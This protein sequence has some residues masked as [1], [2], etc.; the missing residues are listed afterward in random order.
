MKKAGIVIALMA[1][2]GIGGAFERGYFDWLG[3]AALSALV[4]PMTIT[5]IKEGSK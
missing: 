1:L 3:I 5:W 4:V 2:I